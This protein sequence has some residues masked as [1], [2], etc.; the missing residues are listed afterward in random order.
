MRYLLIVDI[1]GTINLMGSHFDVCKV[2]SIERMPF[3]KEVL[4]EFWKKDSKII[5]LTGRTEEELRADTI[6]WL[7]KHE[8]PDLSSIFFYK[9]DYNQWTWESY[10]NF[11]KEHVLRL[12]K[13]YNGYTPIFIDD[14][15]DILRNIQRL[16]I[17]CIRITVPRD[18]EQLRAFL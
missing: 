18:W 4:D 5:Y 2:K 8:F 3:S 10:I 7:K 17:H 12:I 6:E 15:Y 14:N 11:K 1:D 9:G 13:E 16:G